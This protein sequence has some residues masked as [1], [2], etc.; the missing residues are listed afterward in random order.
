[1]YIVVLFFQNVRKPFDIYHTQTDL[2]RLSAI[3]RDLDEEVRV[4]MEATGVYHLPILTFLKDEGFFVATTNPLEMKRYRCQG[5]RTAKTDRSDS[6]II[7]NYGLDFWF[8]LKEFQSDDDY[9]YELRLYPWTALRDTPRLWHTS[10]KVI[11]VRGHVFS[12]GTMYNNK[13]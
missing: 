9:Y 7:A 6:K 12:R 13:K 1:M 4:V 10:L 2:L 5:I 8:H 11:S 3:I